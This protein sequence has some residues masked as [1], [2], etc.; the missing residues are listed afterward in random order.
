MFLKYTYMQTAIYL[1][2]H[3]LSFLGFPKIKLLASSSLLGSE[4]PLTSLPSLSSLSSP[5]VSGSSLAPADWR[6]WAAPQHN[7]HFGLSAMSSLASCTTTKLTPTPTSPPLGKTPDHFCFVL[8]K[9]FQVL[10]SLFWHTQL[11]LWSASDL[12]N[13]KSPN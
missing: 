10:L 8:L 5:S 6:I 11:N 3:L 2:L 9:I 7:C 13:L 1:L 12:A 4:G